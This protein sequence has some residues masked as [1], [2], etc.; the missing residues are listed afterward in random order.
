MHSSKQRSILV[1]TTSSFFMWGIIATIGP[2]SLSFPFLSNVPLQTKTLVLAIGPVVIMLGNLIM[3]ILADKIGRKRVFIA[4]MISYGFGIMFLVFASNLVLLIIGLIL[5]EFGVGGEE[6]S[7]LSLISEDF[8]SGERSKFLTFVANFNNMGAAFISGI[9]LIEAALES[10]LSP[11]LGHIFVGMSGSGDLSF[12]FILLVSAAILVCLMIYSRISLPESYRW[13]RVVGR[14]NEAEH[15]KSKLIIRDREEYVKQPSYL[16]SMMILMVMGVSQY[17]TFGLMAYIIG[18]YNF[19]DNYPV[20]IFVALLGASV[21]GFA[22]MFLINR[23]RRNFT[24]LSFLGGTVSMVVILAFNTMLANMAVFLPLLFVNMIFS[25]FAWASR[26]TL[27]PELVPTRI[28]STS[29]GII[30]LAPMAA[31]VISVYLTAS[32]D[33]YDFILLNLGL[34]SIGF[35]A[36]LIWYIVGIET[37]NVNIDYGKEPS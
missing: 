8:S 2:L 31:Y 10:R 26:T 27:E 20:L 22:A 11:I 1:S 15:E 24:L 4:T 21:A 7:G 32:L 16:F 6:P 18:P 30:R 13:L 14:E 12:R 23:E 34:W 36:A 5:S 9:F 17:L 25:E 29:I 28:R 37:R 19:P 35:I 3:G 33:T